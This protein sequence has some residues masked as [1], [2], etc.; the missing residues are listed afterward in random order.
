[1]RIQVL[2]FGGTSVADPD[3]IKNVAT[4]VI[5]A[6]AQADAIV[7]VVSAMGATTDNLVNMASLV[8]PDP[9]P[10][11]LD[12]LLSSGEQV[13]IALLAMALAA[14]GQPAISF[15]GS[16]VG[17]F[18]SHAHTRARILSVD[19]DQIRVGLDQGKVAVVAGFQGISET[20]QI[21]TLGRGGSDTTALALAAALKAQR[22]EIFT[23]V[24]GIY[25]ADPRQVPT[26]QKLNTISYD[27]MLELAVLGAGVMHPRSIIFGQ[28][29]GIPIHVRHSRKPSTGT[30]ITGADA[31]M[32]EAAVVGCA[33]KADLGRVTLRR[34]PSTEGIQAQIFAAL[35][36]SEIFVDDIIQTTSGTEHINIS[37]TVDHLDLADV[38]PAMSTV[39]AE[40]GHG[41]LDIDVGLSK[42]SVVG[43]GMRSQTGVAAKM[44]DALKD[45]KIK[46]LNIT[47]S[48]IKISCIVNRPDGEKALQ[49][50]HTAFEL[51]QIN[52]GQETATTNVGERSVLLTDAIRESIQATDDTP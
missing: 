9:Q 7:V 1:M 40:L 47:T 18:T 11:E 48:E 32:E 30:I 45:A 17:L 43:L 21:T 6:R 35:G 29:Y 24:D 13:T 4:R 14:Q 25:T 41:E 3:A 44:F 51:D 36:A 10:R 22:C 19:C 23:D 27:E 37:F 5:A 46:I 31:M 28:K 49:A 20:G 33:L 52:D 42:V 8:N 12:M 26:A 16:Q 2:K 39:L 34:L 15:T 50:I 38:K